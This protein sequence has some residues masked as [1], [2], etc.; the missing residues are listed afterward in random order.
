MK[1]MI[2]G[3]CRKT[4]T[5]FLRSIAS[6]ASSINTKEAMKQ[7]YKNLYKGGVRVDM[8]Q[9]QEDLALAVKAQ[10]RDL[11]YNS[12][13]LYPNCIIRHMLTKWTDHPPSICRWGVRMVLKGLGIRKCVFSELASCMFNIRCI[14]I[15]FCCSLFMC[16]H[17]I[18]LRICSCISA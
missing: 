3:L 4:T 6:F 18:S 9:G 12:G 11:C 15:T 13:N 2:N 16:Y 8:I 10:V 5:L 17:Q 14:S 1:S 7:L